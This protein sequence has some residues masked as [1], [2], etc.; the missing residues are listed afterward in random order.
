MTFEV[1]ENTA[2]L[3][4]R[5]CKHNRLVRVEMLTCPEGELEVLADDVLAV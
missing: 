1:V 3:S 5:H 2:I 4:V